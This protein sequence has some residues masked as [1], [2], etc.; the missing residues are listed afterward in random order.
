[1]RQ[2]HWLSVQ[3]RI[4]YK[5]SVLTYKTLNTS[6]PQ[7]LNQHINR[8]VNARR[9]RHCS[10]FRSLVPTSRNV[11][12]DVA[13]RPSGTHFQRL[14]SEATH[15][16]YS[17]LGKKNSYFVGTLASTLNRLPPAPLKLRDY[18]AIQMCLLLLLLPCGERKFIVYACLTC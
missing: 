4:D 18:G 9:L 16:L 13:R 5:V 12:F 3:H 1:M 17:N 14:S 7:Y 2:L 10:S 11:L 6:V 15:C 8:R